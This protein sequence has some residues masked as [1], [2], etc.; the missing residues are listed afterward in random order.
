MSR[1]YLTV[2]IPYVNAEPH[3]GY[4]LELVQADA[5]VRLYRAGGDDVRFL[6]GTDD[7]ALKNAL[8]A[9][10]AGV[11]TQ[12]FVDTN[13]A[14]FEALQAPLDV[15]FDDFI[16]TST[17]PRH[18]PTVEALWRLTAD[19][20]DFYRRRY[21]G[22]YCVGCEQ[23]YSDDELDDGR[24]PEHDT[25]TET[26]AED[27]WFFRLSRYAADIERLLA[28][29]QIR[30]EPEPYANEA[31]SF[32][33]SG[34]QDI[35][36]SRSKSR[37]R[38]WG[39]PVPDD[40]SQVIYVWWDALAN[41]ISALDFGGDRVAYRHWWEEADERIHVI[42]KGILRFHAVY[43]PALLLSAGQ[44]LPTTIFVHPYLT[45]NGRKLSK[46]GGNVVDPVAV[47]DTYGTTALRWWLLVDVPRAADA[48]FTEARLVERHD[49]DLANGVGNL[50]NRVLAMV[51][52]Y[53][54]GTSPRG[55]GG[56]TVP[57]L[58]DAFAVAAEGFDL[59]QLARLVREHVED[60][61]QLVEATAPWALAKAERAGDPAAGKVLDT[62]LAELLGRLRQLSTFLAPLLP[63]LGSA[64]AAA[65]QPDDHGELAPPAPLV[66]RLEPTIS[67]RE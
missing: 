53:R 46:S 31:L 11:P 30:I 2:S 18:R 62:C 52:R 63:G 58:P 27:N 20:G 37:A 12:T 65:L 6:G 66:P 64:L 7:H 41:Y 36:V 60:A 19:H 47:V 32:V 56:D 39:I 45:A 49:T 1:R 5:L 25:A 24:C 14:R 48:D 42:G 61:N 59:R 38:G 34:L 50:T 29:G 9:E 35:S 22:R 40:P 57:A 3:L 10:T 55:E 54:H 13:A 8:A 28:S 4:A 17:D 33:R 26:V 16:R 21:E 43:W 15:R 23:F 44:P 67:P 51:H